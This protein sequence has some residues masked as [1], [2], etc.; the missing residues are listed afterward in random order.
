MEGQGQIRRSFWIELKSKRMPIGDDIRVV[1]VI[2]DITRR[3]YTEK[4]LRELYERYVGFLKTAD[5]VFIHDLA[6]NLFQLIKLPRELPVL[7]RRTVKMNIQH[8]PA[9]TVLSY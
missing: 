6:G 2:E 4:E 8:W 1:A 5:M 9:K 3:K 7:A